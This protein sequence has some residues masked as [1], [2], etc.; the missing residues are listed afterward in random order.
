MKWACITLFILYLNP[1]TVC[2]QISTSLKTNMYE[3]STGFD[4]PDNIPFTSNLFLIQIFIKK[5]TGL[6]DSIED[7]VTFLLLWITTLLTILTPLVLIYLWIYYSAQYIKKYRRV[8]GVKQWVFGKSNI[9]KLNLS[10]AIHL[11][12]RKVYSLMIGFGVAI[13]AYSIAS[14]R[15]MVINF[16]EM[17]TAL[18]QYFKFPFLALD[19]FGLTENNAQIELKFEYFWN[20]MLLIVVISAMFFLIG[21]LIGSLVVDL[22]FKFI[23]EQIEKSRLRIKAKKE[24][25]SLKIKSRHIIPTESETVAH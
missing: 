5:N 13:I 6:T 14:I 21:Y 15:F 9:S 19:E 16:D 4:I 2:S 12:Y 8:F 10:N 17:E 3:L 1:V 11:S 20:Q 22:R 18:I 23:N 7:Y 24:M 25:F